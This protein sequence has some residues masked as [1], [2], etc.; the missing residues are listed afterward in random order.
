M[1][2][3]R[4]TVEWVLRELRA[5]QSEAPPVPGPSVPGPLDILLEPMLQDCLGLVRLY[6]RRLEHEVGEPRVVRHKPAAKPRPAR[7]FTKGTRGAVL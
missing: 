2:V 5:R 4:E 7:R 6:L 1:K 3:R